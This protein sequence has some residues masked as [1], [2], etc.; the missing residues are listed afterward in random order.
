MNVVSTHRISSRLK[1]GILCTLSA[2]PVV[3]AMLSAGAAS[4][5]AAESQSAAAP[6]VE[7]IVVTG[8]RV[9]RDG[10]EAPTPVSVINIE[11]MQNT[12]T[13]NL[14]DYVNTLPSISGST[15]PT[16]TTTVI[17][18]GNGAINGLNLRGLGAVRTLVLLN[19]Q[20]TVGSIN[21][22]VVDV[23]ELPQQ[24]ISRVDVV[25]GGASA[26]YGSDALT[27]VVNFVLDTKFV[28]FK[29]EASGGVTTY[30]DDR[31]WKISLTSGTTFGGDR[32]HFL[33][34]G[35][36][37]ANDGILV[38]N[39]PWN[40][41]GYSFINNPAYGTA[42]GQS[43]SVP[44][45]IATKNVALSNAAPGGMITAG[46][47]KG[48]IF[49]P[50]GT[51]SNL[52]Y[53][54]LVSGVLMSGGGWRATAVADTFGQSL[55]PVTSR[56]N[57]FTRASF[58]ITDDIEIYGQAG[59]SHS[60]NVSAAVPNFYTGSLA[61][62]SDNAFLPAALA[63]QLAPGSTISVGTTNYDIGT[64]HPTYDRRVLRFLVGIDGN[65]DAFDT[66]WKWDAYYST[67]FS[68]GTSA[69]IGS[70]FSPKYALAIDAVRNPA[71][72]AI[73]C[74]STLTA[75]TNGCV[76]YN[77]FGI[78]VN[79]QAAI[80]YVR[81]G[82]PWFTN[83]MLQKV[84]AVS[85]SGEPFSTWAGPVSI[86]T[87]IEHREESTRAA[88]D[89]FE[90]TG[91]WLLASGV[92][93]AG[94]FT[95]NEGFVETVIPLAKD[96]VWAKNFEVN[97]A[98]RA[99]GYST[100]GTTATWKI[101]VN[102]SLTDDLRFRGVRSHDIREPTLV[103]L[104]SAAVTQTN[105]L[106]DPFLNNAQVTYRG[107]TQGNA[108]LQPEKAMTTGLG[109]V[110]QPSFFPGFSV[111]FDYYHIN[112]TGAIQTF[113]PVQLINLCF[114]GNQA[115]CSTF[116]RTPD[117]NGGL[118]TL[119]FIAGPQ[120]FAFEN[121]KGFD[122]EASYQLALDTVNNDWAG[123]LGF[124]FLTTHAIEYTTNSGAV[125][126][127]PI[128]TAGQLSGG[129]P[130][131]WRFEG[132]MNY[133]LDPITVGLTI[134]GITGGK[135]NNNF[136]EC[137]SG[138]PVSTGNNTTVSYNHIDGA[139]FF[140][141]NAAYKIHVGDTATSELFFSVRN[142]MNKDPSTVY[143]GPNNSSWTFYPTANQQF[144]VLGRVFRAGV[145]FKM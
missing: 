35:E 34:S 109:A 25:T 62:K 21:T 127:I 115:A 46:P 94:K 139:T 102:Y 1:Q 104:F 9:V 29:G 37:A 122:I 19:G 18:G 75:P 80:T 2:T 65:L 136:I 26:A 118:P 48:V 44:A 39:R 124:R 15:T 87:G 103:D 89:P 30:G 114:V 113:S 28:G 5:T 17:N 91:S 110:Y 79:S 92:P 51:Y 45:Q 117:P 61:V 55:V 125:G 85:I 84:A 98:V 106:T 76:P 105:S 129:A 77:L 74:R 54:S 140:D 33:I 23:T 120:N 11:E 59:W 100:F 14:A 97:G 56:Q 66:S 4:A 95:V 60:H 52:Q 96:T 121:A 38:N 7:E 141:I 6:A 107:T 42:A 134:R 50:G 22:G 13:N 111:S 70:V 83:R 68:M 73:V 53:G 69:A 16:S 142:L 67:G 12:A 31:N 82:D 81:G 88:S 24:L 135:I 99:T 20:R 143:I 119:A 132:A 36:I 126:S 116:T 47:L 27:G 43:T 41:Q 144:D 72:G 32:G 108:N 10:Y 145:R 3:A 130:A 57:L 123:K 137:T 8:T 138:C 131:K 63:T 78:G 58:Q 86:A 71:T 128:N 90:A 49:G 93:F 64:E 133:S 112:I 40:Q 101:G